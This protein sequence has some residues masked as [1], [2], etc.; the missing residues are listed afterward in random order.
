MI[1][2]AEKDVGAAHLKLVAL[3]VSVGARPE[4]LLWVE[5]NLGVPRDPVAGAWP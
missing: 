1:E 5:E 3:Q 2:I 4:A